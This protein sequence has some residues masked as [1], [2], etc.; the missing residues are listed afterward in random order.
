MNTH[1]IT[2]V[3]GGSAG[4]MTAAT[5]IKRFP[6]KNITLIESPNTPIIGVGESTIGQIN[7]WLS[8]IGVKDEEFMPYTDASYKMSIRFEDFYKKGDG[9]FHYP[10]GEAYY[11]DY[12][13]GRKTW[14]M[15][16]ILQPE[17]PYYDYAES[18]YP[19]MS[20]VRNKT[21]VPH[22]NHNLPLHNFDRN[23]A[24]HF[25][26]TKFGIWLRDN[27]CIPKGVKHIVE[28]I[29]SV[30]TND[31]GVKSLNKKY[32]ADLFIDCTGF[33]SMLLG[34]ALKEPFISYSDM[35]PNNK[36]WA[37]RV[38]YKDKENQLEPYTNC[39]AIENGWVWNI[40]SWERIGTGYVY[41][42]KYVSDEE[43]L[44]EFKRH[45]D[46]KGHDYSKS[47]F[48]NI[49]MRVGR[50]ERVFVKNVA[51]IGLSAGFI[52]PLESNG[53]YSTHEFLHRLVRILNRGD[54]ETI[55]QFDKDSYDSACKSNFDEFAEFVAAHYALSHREDTEYWRDV[56]K[57]Q[58]SKDLIN[59]KPSFI[60]GFIS[61]AYGKFRDY[62]HKEGGFDNISIG[63]RNLPIDLDTLHHSEI[64]RDE[65][66]LKN[67]I[68]N[69]YRESITKMEINKFEWDRFAKKQIKMIDYLK[70]IHNAKKL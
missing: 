28:D 10:F 22:N 56:N 52:E 58:Y 26:A 57:R 70:E 41:S 42:D 30:E 55:S 5:L 24:Y 66:E 43:A 29:T 20:L 23:V 31:D 17:T 25:D 67:E 46:K 18:M 48:K 33:K 4:W 9:G 35:L 60:T 21:I 13:Q 7:Q 61:F 47:E 44:N 63:M 27:F 51:A 62:E 37:T 53:L 12:F 69:H 49:K 16:K 6:K 50:H 14:I 8:M 11:S 64:I 40:P 54:K 39:T 45:L 65:D 3:G 32:T 59:L 1:N 2:I 19:I 34:G 38:P 15:K 36:A 68:E